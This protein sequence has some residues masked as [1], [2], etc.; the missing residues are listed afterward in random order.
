MTSSLIQ[1]KCISG[2]KAD[3][4]PSSFI[5]ESTHISVEEILDQWRQAGKAGNSHV[6]YFKVQ[7]GDK[8]QYLLKHDLKNDRWTIENR[9]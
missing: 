9:R 4:R 1:V 3:E 5:H 8:H 7:G 6:D 2:H